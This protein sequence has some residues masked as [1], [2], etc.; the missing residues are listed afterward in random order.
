MYPGSWVEGLN[1]AGF[2]VAGF[3]LQSHGWSQG[4]RGL[5][6]FCEEFDHLCDDLRRFADLTAAARS[7]LR[8]LFLLHSAGILS[9][10][11]RA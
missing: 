11:K 1:Q 5:H 4:A 3:D 9:R 7:G 6:V 2:S 10:S 8:G